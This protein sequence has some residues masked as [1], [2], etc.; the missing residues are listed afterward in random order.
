M[1]KKRHKT[2]AKENIID[3]A[4]AQLLLGLL[5]LFSASLLEGLSSIGST[6]LLAS[7]FRLTG[8]VDQLAG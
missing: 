7:F 6:V 5:I 3:R 4:V 1:I 2:I 8:S